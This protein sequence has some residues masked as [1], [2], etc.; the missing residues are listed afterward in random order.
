MQFIVTAYDGQDADAPARRLAARPAHLKL[1]EESV[2]RGEQI[3]GAAIL[4]DQGQMRGSLMVM[5]FP[6]RAMLDAWLDREPYVTEKV[7]ENIDVKTCAIAPSFTH[8]LNK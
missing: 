5:N 4:D 3:L 7:W 1:V 2:A 8:L 6:S